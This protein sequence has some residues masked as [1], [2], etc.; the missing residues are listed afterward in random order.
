MAHSGCSVDTGTHVSVA[1]HS[2]ATALESLRVLYRV[3]QMPA[4]NQESTLHAGGHKL[5]I[6]VSTGP[7]VFRGF[8]G[9]FFL[10]LLASDTC[11]RP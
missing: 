6:Q 2:V 1:G 5:D 7:L 11:M 9:L 10:L 3:P 8:E 4:E